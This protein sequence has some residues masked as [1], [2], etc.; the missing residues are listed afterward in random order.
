MRQSGP[1]GPVGQGRRFGWIRSMRTGLRLMPMRLLALALALLLLAA[2]NAVVRGVVVQGD[3][4]R[5]E[6]ARQSDAAAVCQRLP[7]RERRI[8]CHAGI[9]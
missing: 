2:F 3:A 6:T 9:V 7:G 4:R 5:V 8:R 1:G